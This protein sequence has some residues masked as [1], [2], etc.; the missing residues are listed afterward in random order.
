MTSF[1]FSEII[2][3]ITVFLL[4]AAI[5]LTVVYFRHLNQ[6][7]S[8]S[9]LSKMQK[10]SAPKQPSELLDL[11][12]NFDNNWS[13]EN[14]S[15]EYIV[16]SG[17]EKKL[18]K[19]IL[20]TIALNGESGMLIKQVSDILELHEI[21]VSYALNY[22]NEKGFIESVNSQKGNIFYL[23]SQGTSYCSKKGFLSEVA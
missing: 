23:T 8:D 19:I 10:K 5:P 13:P 20:K 17:T 1:D 2:V 21:E 15:N 4:V 6:K 3:W 11:K 16:N 14:L 7:N 22:L 9:L 18:A 12:F